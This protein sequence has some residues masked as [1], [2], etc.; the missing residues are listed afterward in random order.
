MNLRPYQQKAIETLK[1]YNKGKVIFPTGAGKTVVMLEDVRQRINSSSSPLNFVIVAPKI[2]LAS[3]LASQFKSYLQKENIYVTYVHSGEDGT[4]NVSEI[5]TINNLV[6]QFNTHHLIFTTYKSLPKINEANIEI[7]YC[8]FDEAHHST[9]QSNFVGVAQTSAISKN[10]Y[11]FTATPKHND[12][13]SSMC[14]SD[15]YGGTILSIPANYLV[16]NG[17]ILP[18]KIETYECFGDDAENVLRFVKNIDI[19]NPKILVAAPST[20]V[21]MDMFTETEL[22][23][24]LEELGFHILH[25]TSKYG[26]VVNNKKVS[27]EEFFEILSKLGSNDNEKFIVFHYAILSEGID[28]PGLTHALLLRNLPFIELAQTIGR[29]VRMNKQDYIDIQNGLIEPGDF[30]SYRKP[31]GIVSVPTKSRRGDRIAQRL[32]EVVNTIFVEGKV[33]IA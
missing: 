29:I 28:C 14:N 15:V 32:Q 31:C 8:Y 1:Q 6:K 9:S 24:E 21:I 23:S 4:T 2:L 19:V 13:Q 12:T 33:L 22:L 17:Y 11:F 18:P 5:I 10:T 3:Q 27:R 20:Q 30:E 7:D 25:I 16:K 26:A